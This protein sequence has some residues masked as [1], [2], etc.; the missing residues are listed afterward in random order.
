MM[1]R[2]PALLVVHPR[3]ARRRDLPRLQEHLQQQWEVTMQTS[4]FPGHS[5]LMVREW[6][7]HTDGFDGERVIFT[8]G[9]DGTFHEAI[10]GWSDLEFPG[11]VRFAP[12]PFGAGNDFLYSVDRAF[13]T[14][15]PFFERPLTQRRDAD[16]GQI[17]FQ[18]G[19][20]RGSRYFCVG[21]TAGFSALVTFR[22]ARLAT[23]V[24]GPLSY[25]LSLFGSLGAWR[26]C[27]VRIEHQDEPFESETFFNFNAANVKY[28]GGGM[29]NAPDACPFAGHLDYVRMNLTLLGALRGLPENFRGNFD[30][31]AGVSVQ[32]SLQPLRITCGRPCPVQADG[33]PLGT[34]PMTIDCLPGHLPLLLPEP[35]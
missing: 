4:D 11:S 35:H 31:I 12:L 26:N 33:E 23:V 3:A 18:D 9:G 19:A 25:L 7:H 34:T 27:W 32:Q 24:P 6:L 16:L 1:T 20:D 28:Y 14:L 13:R 21:A 2:N 17:H 5:R 8:A 22:R 30:R 29:I 15:A 10:N